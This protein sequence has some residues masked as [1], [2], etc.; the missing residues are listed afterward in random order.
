M[1]NCPAKS[2]KMSGIVLHI[3]IPG[4]A[5]MPKSYFGP[6]TSINSPSDTEQGIL[7]QFGWDAIFSGPE[8]PGPG[9]EWAYIVCV[10]T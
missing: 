3:Q 5:S 10:H 2:C 8:D 9:P 4:L 7:Q 1:N 6:G